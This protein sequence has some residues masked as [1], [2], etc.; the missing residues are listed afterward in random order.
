MAWWKSSANNV[1]LS[2]SSLPCRV[3]I[4]AWEY[5]SP[6]GSGN[7]TEVLFLK[8][9]ASSMR[10]SSSDQP[11]HTTALS[12]VGSQSSNFISESSAVKYCGDCIG[13]ESLL[14]R[15]FNSI[16]ILCSLCY[17]QSGSKYFEQRMDPAVGPFHPTCCSFTGH[18]HLAQRPSLC[19]SCSPFC[20]LYYT[21]WQYS[22]LA[23]FDISQK[24]IQVNR[25]QYKAKIS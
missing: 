24:G 7:S 20:L 18:L 6:L 14:C 19:V 22:A 17:K 10:V 25:S 16:T 8:Y 21:Q 4:A 11:F 23:W 12:R 1:L 9:P 15:N 2:E 3:F 13:F 5:Y